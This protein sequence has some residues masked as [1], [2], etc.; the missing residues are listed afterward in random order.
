MFTFDFKGPSNF[1]K[2]SILSGIY[3]FNN[4]LFKYPSMSKLINGSKLFSTVFSKLPFTVASLFAILTFKSLK[5]I[6]LFL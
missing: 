5:L 1:K 4:L 2:E 6:V 3:D